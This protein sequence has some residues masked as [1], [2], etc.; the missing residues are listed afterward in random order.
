MVQTR[1]SHLRQKRPVSYWTKVL[2]SRMLISNYL[3]HGSDFSNSKGRTLR[4]LVTNRP[5]MPTSGAGIFLRNFCGQRSYFQL[6]QAFLHHPYELCA[7]Y[8][9]SLPLIG[10]KS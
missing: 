6:A 7:S 3:V 10:C 5:D 8:K 4:N 9:S 2:Q 1:A